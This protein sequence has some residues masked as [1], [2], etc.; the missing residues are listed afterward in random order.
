MKNCGKFEARELRTSV[1]LRV[2][3]ASNRQTYSPAV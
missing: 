1:N 3:K 2:N